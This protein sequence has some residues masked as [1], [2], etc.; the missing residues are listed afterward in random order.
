MRAGILGKGG[1]GKTTISAGFAY[2]AAKR[3][4]NMQNVLVID[5][6]QNVNLAPTLG[7][8]TPTD[9]AT[10]TDAIKSYVKGGR[11]DVSVSHMIGTTPPRA[12]SQFIRVSDSD[13]FLQTYAVFKDNLILLQAGSYS[14]S[15]VGHTC[16]H[17]ILEPVELVYHHLLDTQSDLVICDSTA[18]LDSL[19]NSLYMVHDYIYFIVEP[20]HK[21]VTVFKQFQEIAKAQNIR[22]RYVANKVASPEDILFIESHLGKQTE[23]I[24]FSHSAHIKALEQ[25]K[26]DALSDFVAEQEASFAKLFD[27]IFAQKKDWSRYY[28]FLCKAHKTIAESWYDEYF[29]TPISKQSAQHFSYENVMETNK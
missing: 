7:L 20:T 26:A 29:Q 21:S 28:Q 25:G 4:A 10:H 24:V 19:G 23:T 2:Y 17:T 11:D 27:H 1:S 9:L 14:C 8:S 3:L 18:G 12:Q 22:V 16:Y 13:S 15:D 5:A 6:D